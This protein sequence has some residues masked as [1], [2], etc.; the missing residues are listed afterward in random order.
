[1]TN[2]RVIH[3]LD[4]SIT[5]IIENPEVF[6]GYYAA[7]LQ[8]LR[9]LEARQ[10]ISN[11]DNIDD[12]VSSLVDR[13]YAAM[14]QVS[15]D[16]N[17]V[18]LYVRLKYNKEKWK[19]FLRKFAATIRIESIPWPPRAVTVNRQGLADYVGCDVNEVRSLKLVS[20]KERRLEKK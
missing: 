3:F 13:F 6:G 5:K 20:E 19:G 14:N 15:E 17:E 1:M 7:E 4:E 16:D 12:A 8:V 11:P 10:A 18:R 9:L 2:E